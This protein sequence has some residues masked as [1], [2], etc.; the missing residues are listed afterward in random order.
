MS[1]LPAAVSPVVPEAFNVADYLVTRHVREGHGGRIA[2]I[3]LKGRS[4]TASWM[5]W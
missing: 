4:P 3:T 5:R 2:L 1:S